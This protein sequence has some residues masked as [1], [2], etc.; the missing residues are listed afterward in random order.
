MTI[1]YISNKLKK[2][3]STPMEIM[4]NYG[5][6]AKK[7]NQ[8]MKELK[9]SANLQVMSSIPAAGCHPLKGDMFGEYAVSISGNWRIIFTLDHDPKPV[10]EDGSI[11]LEKVTNIIITSV[12]DYH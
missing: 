5:V 8:R 9:A 3:L 6:R 10:K 2:S 1:Y 4:K 11:D 12:D 7:V